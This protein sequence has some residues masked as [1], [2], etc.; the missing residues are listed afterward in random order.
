MPVRRIRQSE[1]KALT[2]ATHDPQTYTLF[3]SGKYYTA[4]KKVS[5][6]AIIAGI[7]VFLILFLSLNNLTKPEDATNL[8]TAC[9]VVGILAG[10]GVRSRAWYTGKDQES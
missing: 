2:R 6:G 7:A 8:G 5:G 4:G 3:K 9:V 10:L 1:F